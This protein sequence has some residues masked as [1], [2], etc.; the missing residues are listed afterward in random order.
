MDAVYYILASRFQSGVDE[1]AH[2]LFYCG[3]PESVDSVIP[4][5]RSYTSRLLPPETPPVP[6]RATRHTLDAHYLLTMLPLC[7]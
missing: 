7:E 4:I 6:Y 1:T 3:M 2:T 5:L